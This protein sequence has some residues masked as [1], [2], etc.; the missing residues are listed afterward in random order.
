MALVTRT[1]RAGFLRNSEAG[2]NRGKTFRHWLTEG[3]RVFLYDRKWYFRRVEV[4]GIEVE[5]GNH[6]KLKRGNPDRPG[7]GSGD[8]LSMEVFLYPSFKVMLH[9]RMAHRLYESGH[10]LGPLYF[11]EGGEKDRHRDSSGGQDRQ[12]LFHRPWQRRHH[13]RDNGDREQRY[14]VS[15]RDPGRH[16]QGRGEAPSTMRDNVMISAGAKVLDL[17]PSARI[18]RSGPGA[19][20]SP[21]PA[22]F[23][24]GR[25]ARQG[26]AQGQSAVARETMDQVHLP[27]PVREDI[28]NLQKENS[29]LINRVLDLENRLKD[30]EKKRPHRAAEQRGNGVKIYNTL[31]KKKEESCPSSRGRCACM[32]VALPCII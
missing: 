10:Y 6:S 15:G 29:I 30:L 20:Y 9:Y 28:T 5:N 18:P 1:K 8:S 26:G 11:P 12:G 24:G 2:W 13:R 31:S 16:G 4:F 32:C 25:G 7:A 3:F 27:D 22:Q 19:W 21:R 14:P 23:H 17:L